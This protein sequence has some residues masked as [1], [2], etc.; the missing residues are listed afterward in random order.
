MHFSTLANITE[1]ALRHGAIIFRTKR[2]GEE[3]G[4]GE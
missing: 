2:L 1:F 4:L 3:E